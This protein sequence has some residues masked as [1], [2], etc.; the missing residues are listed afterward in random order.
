MEMR[1]LLK[2]ME[3]NNKGLR[4]QRRYNTIILLNIG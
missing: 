4:K 2:E 1:M 3:K